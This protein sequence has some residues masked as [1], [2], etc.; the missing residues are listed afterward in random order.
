MTGLDP[1]AS[2]GQHIIRSDDGAA[3]LWAGAIDDLWKLGK[4]V[5]QGGP[6]KDTKVQAGEVSDPY[7]IGF[8]DKKSLR[9]SHDAATAVGFRIEVEPIGHGPWM[10]YQEVSIQPGE[11]FEHVFPAHFQARWIRFVADKGCRTTAW[12]EYE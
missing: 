3:A 5:G 2:S 8:Y 10:L 9:L 7:L 6:W 11:T 4:P 12:L 1:A